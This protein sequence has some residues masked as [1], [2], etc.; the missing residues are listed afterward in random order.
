MAVVFPWSSTYLFG[1]EGGLS[2]SSLFLSLIAITTISIHLPVVSLCDIDHIDIPACVST[3]ATA[4][5]SF[6]CVY[7]C[8]DTAKEVLPAEREPW[9]DDMAITS[10]WVLF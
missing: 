7:I 1:E 8:V 2:F 9:T 3:S 6:Q 10:P 4:L 5:R